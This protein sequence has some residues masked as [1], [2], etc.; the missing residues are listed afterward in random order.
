MMSKDTYRN[1]KGTMKVLFILVN[2]I[3]KVI[4]L[5]TLYKIQTKVMLNV[6][7]KSSQKSIFI[8]RN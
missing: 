8:G 5:L 2:E 1:E 6:K 7:I 3:D 4:Q